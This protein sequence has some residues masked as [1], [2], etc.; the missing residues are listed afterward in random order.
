AQTCC[1]GPVDQNLRVLHCWAVLKTDPIAYPFNL[2]LE[3]K[4]IAAETPKSLVPQ[5]PLVGLMS[6]GVLT[7]TQRHC[8][9]GCSLYGQFFVALRIAAV[10]LD[11]GPV[12]T[13]GQFRRSH[14]GEFGSRVD[15]LATD[16]S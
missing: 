16:N 10:F 4:A 8:L 2:E 14:A 6:D 5:D 11:R 12:G 1:L 9:A 3:S 13:Y 7:I 15:Y